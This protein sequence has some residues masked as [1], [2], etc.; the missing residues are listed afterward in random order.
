[1]S[2]KSSGGQG[3]ASVEWIANKAGPH[4]GTCSVDPAN[5]ANVTGTKTINFDVT[6]IHAVSKP[7]AG[8]SLAAGSGKAIG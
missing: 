6:V 1:V 2:V 4:G 7:G 5:M 8:G 3:T